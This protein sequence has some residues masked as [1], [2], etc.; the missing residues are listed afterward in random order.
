M[1]WLELSVE[2]SPEL[3]EPLVE[4]FQR[5]GRRQVVVEEAGGFN[6]DEGEEPPAGGPVVVRAYVPQ[7]RRSADRVARIQAGVQ[8]MG[9][10]KP[11]SPLEVRTVS[12]WEWEEAWKAHFRPLRIGQR[13][14][15]VPTWHEHEAEEGD[16]VLTLDPGLAF[17]TGHHPTTRMCLEQ[18]ERRVSPGMRILDLGTGSGLLAQAAL[19][20]GAEWAL[21]LDTEPDAIR[22]S[23]R[24]LKAAGLSRRVKIARGTLPH[25]Q[26]TG[27]DLTVA[28]ISAK[29]LVELAGEIAGTLRPGG[30]LIASGVL[31]ERGDEVREAMLAAGFEELET[32]QTE[33]WLALSFRRTG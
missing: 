16:I 19:L 15:V 28:N 11:L 23:R 14:V 29:V 32:Q 3:V 18:L 4:L 26:A 12:P 2:A 25:P 9:L 22:S 20:L 8:L 1:D 33:D 30:T 17:G 10:I 24:N 6:P 7:D 27:L 31:E 21:A 5:Y 13:L